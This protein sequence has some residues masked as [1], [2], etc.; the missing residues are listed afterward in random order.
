MTGVPSGH[1]PAYDVARANAPHRPALLSA[2][3]AVMDSNQ[4]ILGGR[5]SVF[6]Q[7]FAAQAGT[8]HCIGVGNGLDALTLA[9]R[10]LGV[11]PGDEVIVPAFTFIATWFA[12]SALGARPVPVD[13][14]HDG[15][16]NPSLIHAAVTGRTRAIV[17]VHLFGRVADMD[18]IMDI[19][20]RAGLPVVEDAAQAHGA[21]RGGRLSG[22]FGTL[23]AFSF[24]PTKNLGALGDGG[25]VCTS[26]AT[27]AA[28]VRSLRNYGSATKNRHDA[29]GC[30][31]RL[32][33]LQA[34]FL[35]VKLPDLTAANDRRRSLARRYLAALSGL[36]DMACPA[37]GD[38]GM[39][40]HQFV[41][42]SPERDSLR[43]R[44]ALAG[45]GTDIHYPTAPF[46]QP[47]YAGH[48]DRVRFPVAAEL[49]SQVLSLPMSDYL[50]EAEV[51]HVIQATTEVTRHAR[52]AA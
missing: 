13:V 11:G 16:M 26:D 18:A 43:S 12:A 37:G 24:Y 1:V 38:D 20:G 28:S 46:D 52:A 33:D 50:S 41:V 27:L 36:P 5:L 47:C 44:L 32:D 40:W 25:A 22:S 45:V 4:F 17:P 8:A 15:N 23:S 30:N 19:A 21:E 49:A 34:A 35:T 51:C 3:A 48:Y 9:L 14:A 31:S 6:E 39:V 7:S 2:M 10:A 42:R 29:L